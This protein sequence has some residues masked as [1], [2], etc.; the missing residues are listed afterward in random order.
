MSLRVSSITLGATSHVGSAK[1]ENLEGCDLI[2]VL[3]PNGSGKSSLLEPL[4][5][6]GAAGTVQ[7]IASK[8]GVRTKF[9]ATGVQQSIAFITSQDLMS[10]VRDLSGALALAT[11]ATRRFHE[12]KALQEC[13]KELRDAPPVALAEPP[14]LDRHRSAYLDAESQCGDQPRTADRYVE[15]GRRLAERVG[16][17][18][19]PLPPEYPNDD[20][21]ADEVKLQPSSRS[22]VGADAVTA[23]LRRLSQLDLQP[24]NA[25]RPAAKAAIAQR[26]LD[27]ALKASAEF[28][29]MP[30]TWSAD[31]VIK[32]LDEKVK[33]IMACVDA[34]SR[35]A[36][37]RRE[38]HAYL[39]TATAE[40]LA[41]RCPV[42]DG[43]I[44]A[45]ALAMK[46]ETNM[47]GAA[48]MDD[49]ETRDWKSAIARAESD[50][51]SIKSVSEE[52]SLCINAASRAWQASRD[53]IGDLLPRLRA[54]DNWAAEVQCAARDL[55]ADCTEWLGSYIG[56]QSTEAEVSLSAL[57]SKAE[58]VAETLRSAE[59][60]LNADLAPRQQNFN[61]FQ[62]LGRLLHARHNL[63]AVPW[64]VDLARDESFKRAAHCRNRW[65]LLLG[66]MAEER[67]RSA[68]EA[69]EEV[70]G[71]PRTRELFARLLERLSATQRWLSSLKYNGK[72]MEPEGIELEK[73]ALSEG[74]TV[75]VNLAAVITVASV[76]VGKEDH[77]PGWLVL[78][79]PTNGLDPHSSAAVSDY[80]GSM[81]LEDLPAQLFVATFDEG[82][83]KALREGALKSGRRVRV[84][85]LPVFSRLPG[86]SFESSSDDTYSP[87]NTQRGLD[88]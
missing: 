17:E 62:S 81:T 87:T 56:A 3:G 50:G 63:N 21:L 43:P 22:L 28:H 68:K 2:I 80:L 60:Q 77:L 70:L 44:D 42:C 23:V 7:G 6:P 72:L 85:T 51:V 47:A 83:A 1:V 57:G 45:H 16:I 53:T 29:A 4:R 15:M 36:A 39:T 24:P 33:R 71:D 14:E 31:E 54:A 74:Q 88:R 48:A 69:N 20:R 73:T 79:E 37:C 58:V 35:V 65:I 13:A 5:R 61:A 52:Q 19:A 32:N 9:V 49:Q 84:V 75:L 46:L 59:S 25:D 67:V 38:A 82:F 76:V 34:K 18:W 40:G 10:E 66:Q 78:D 41:N 26:D 8:S 55:H 30:A 86:A 64:S 12:A 11:N 27:K